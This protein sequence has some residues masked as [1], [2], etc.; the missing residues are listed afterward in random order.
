MLVRKIISPFLILLYLSAV[1]GLGFY[2]CHCEHSDRLVLLTYNHCDCA[3]EAYGQH[4]NNSCG[5]KTCKHSNESCAD[6]DG[7]CCKVVYKSIDIDQETSNQ[8][9]KN[10]S[11]LLVLAAVLPSIIDIQ[12]TDSQT[13]PFD[14]SKSPPEG[15]KTP[16]IYHNCQ[17]RL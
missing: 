9:A 5:E 16:L 8:E 14:F 7:D 12:D 6:E 4:K 1:I 3:H 2:N 15:L 17:L 11:T 13:N 10:L